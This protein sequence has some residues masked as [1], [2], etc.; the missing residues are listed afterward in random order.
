MRLNNFWNTFVIKHTSQ[1]FC[2]EYFENKSVFV[3]FTLRVIIITENRYNGECFKYE[4][5]P[6]NAGYIYV[7][8]SSNVYRYIL[9]FFFFFLRLRLC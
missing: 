4:N 8:I 6:N 5:Y 9:I 1:G 2:V 7:N 3:S